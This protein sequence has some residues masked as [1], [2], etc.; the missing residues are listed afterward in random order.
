MDST[1][2]YVL[3]ALYALYLTTYIAVYVVASVHTTLPVTGQSKLLESHERWRAAQP[4]LVKEDTTAS[5]AIHSSAEQ[6]LLPLAAPL[7]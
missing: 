5:K 1:E 6:L 3:Y 7:A 2:K 4:A